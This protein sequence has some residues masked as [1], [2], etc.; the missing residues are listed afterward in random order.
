MEMNN[1]TISGIF[2][3]Y[4]IGLVNVKVDMEY[5]GTR[6]IFYGIKENCDITIDM[7]FGKENKNI[8]TET[9]KKQL[10]NLFSRVEE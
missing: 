3:E 10:N 5:A 4:N 7:K 8:D 9:I 1:E 2:A 6:I